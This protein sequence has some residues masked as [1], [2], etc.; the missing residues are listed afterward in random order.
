MRSPCALLCL[1]LVAFW[2]VGHW[3]YLRT[4]YGSS[5][6]WE[7]LALGAVLALLV[8]RWRDGGVTVPSPPT[9]GTRW[10]ALALPTLVVC[11]YALAFPWLP[12]LG[13][14]LL[15]VTALSLTAARLWVGQRSLL[16]L[17]G[18]GLLALPVIPLFQYQL[19]YPLRSSIAAVAAPLLRLSGLDVVRAGTSLEWAGRLVWVDAPCSGMRMLWSGLFLTFVLAAFLRLDNRR[20]ALA[21]LGAVVVLLAAN[22]LRTS[23]LFM[24]EAGLVPAPGWA[25]EAVGAMA[26]AVTAL[27]ITAVVPR[28]ARE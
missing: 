25:H 14:A 26:Y 8:V 4:R 23:A 1:Q 10:P 16:A 13:R 11:V 5:E 15:A 2:P 7:M 20:T 3:L 6:R 18:L 24:V 28:L 21:A 19:G 9:T 27:A 12:P 22:I 17:W